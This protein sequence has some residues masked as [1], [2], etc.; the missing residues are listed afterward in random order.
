[1]TDTR[2]FQRAYS[3]T[4][5]AQRAIDLMD[6]ARDLGTAHGVRALTLTAIAE[7]AGVHVSGVRRYYDSREEILIRLTQEGYE[8]W[9]ADLTGVLRD[10]GTL[11]V[12]QLADAFVSSLS[13]HPLLCDLLTHSTLTLEHEASYD[14]IRDFK[15]SAHRCIRDLTEVV[16]HASALDRRGAEIFIAAAISLAATLWQAGHPSR[17]VVRL[18]TEEPELA[19]IGVDFEPALTEQLVA[20]GTGLTTVTT[21]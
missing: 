6:A 12:A 17:N 4:Q 19:H 14:V 21:S 20:L 15:R 13:R 1:M 7:Q 16:E 3:A 8:H 5:K 11:N 18:Y 2:P 10:G 9:T